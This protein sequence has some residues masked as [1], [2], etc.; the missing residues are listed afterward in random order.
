MSSARVLEL[1]GSCSSG[2]RA[3]RERSSPSLKRNP[4]SKCQGKTERAKFLA[5][6]VCFSFTPLARFLLLATVRSRRSARPLSLWLSFL[7]LEYCRDSYSPALIFW[8]VL[9]FTIPVVQSLARRNT[10]PLELRKV[11]QVASFLLSCCGTPAVTLSLEALSG[12]MRETK[13]DFF[14]CFT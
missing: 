13:S 5:R 11:F 12:G 9:W 3:V 10:E 8:T 14:P 6:V 4:A 7:S 2:A 1:V